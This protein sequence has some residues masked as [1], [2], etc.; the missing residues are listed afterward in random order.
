M[1]ANESKRGSV[2]IKESQSDRWHYRDRLKRWYAVQEI[3]SCSC[4]TFLSGPAWVLLSM[5]CT[6]FSPS[7]YII[8]VLIA[9]TS[10]FSVSNGCGAL[11]FMVKRALISKASFYTSLMKNLRTTLHYSRPQTNRCTA[12]K[13]KPNRKLNSAGEVNPTDDIALPFPPSIPPSLQTLLPS[14]SC[15][16]PFSIPFGNFCHVCRQVVR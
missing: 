7:Q 1:E 16:L 10:R 13:G 11:N 6:L 15:T 5:I 3:S 12:W 14:L 4:L 8:I 9:L 2:D